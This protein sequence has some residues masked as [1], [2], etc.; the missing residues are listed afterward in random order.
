MQLITERNREYQTRK[1]CHTNVNADITGKNAGNQR[2]GSETFRRDVEREKP[3]VSEAA[4]I[5]DYRLRSE[6]IANC[7]IPL[8]QR[9]RERESRERNQGEYREREKEKLRERKYRERE[10]K[11]KWKWKW[12]WDV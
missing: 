12:V 8:A 2:K 6:I 11:W 7:V 3:V 5:D 1:S 4:F 9:E 10:G